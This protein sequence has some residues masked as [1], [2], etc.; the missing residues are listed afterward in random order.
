MFDGT[1]GLPLVEEIINTQF[2]INK[3]SFQYKIH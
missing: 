3:H 2:F 1:L